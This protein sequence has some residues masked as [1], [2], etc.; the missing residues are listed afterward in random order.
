MKKEYIQVKLHHRLYKLH[1][2]DIRQLSK[3]M[4]PRTPRLPSW[5]EKNEDGGEFMGTMDS[6]CELVE[7]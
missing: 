1:A 6:E 3:I 7:E 5:G 4:Y 2:S